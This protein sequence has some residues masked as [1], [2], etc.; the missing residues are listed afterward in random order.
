MSGASIEETRTDVSLGWHQYSKYRTHTWTIASS[1]EN[2]YQSVALGWDFAIENRKRWLTLL[3]SLSVS[4][5]TLSPTDAD[6]FGGPRAQAD[7]ETK[8]S[9]SVYGGFNL[10]VNAM[11]T[12]Q[13]GAGLTQLDGYLSDPY[14]GADNRPDQR[15]QVVFDVLLRR[16]VGWL[17]AAWH[18]DYRYYQDDWEVKAHTIDQ[19][20]YKQ[21]ALD[22]GSFMLGP[23][24]R[25]YWQH[26]AS[27]YDLSST[28]SEPFYSSDYRLS[29]YGALSVGLALTWDWHDWGVS[30]DISQY[31][32]DET[33]GVTG[34]QDTETPALVDFTTVSFGLF[35]RF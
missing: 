20:L 35:T 19:H 23:N 12:L 14:R 24:V 3:S 13:M 18:V 11:T 7:G 33:W 21:W 34:K 25:Y 9:V 26:Q 31:L 10:V 15:Q 16:Y 8:T 29:A 32:S 4:Y 30:L 22:S 17:G 5:D 1:V 27:F 2:D 6:V 28:P